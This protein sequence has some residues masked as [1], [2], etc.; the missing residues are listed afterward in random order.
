[1]KIAVISDTHLGYTRFYED[2][3]KQAEKAFAVAQEIS[4][5]IIFAG[6]MFDSKIPSLDTMERA[7]RILRE[8]KVPIYGISGNHERR[9]HS[10]DVLKVF[11][12]ARMFKKIGRTG[13]IIEK[14]GERIFVVGM[15]SLP[16][17]LAEKGLEKLMKELVL[18]KGT[19]SILVLHQT[20]GIGGTLLP[21]KL[22]GLPFE[23]IVNGHMHEHSIRGKILQP[24]STVITQLKKEETKPK[25]FCIYNTKTKE[26]EFREI[27]S[28]K[29]IME[30][31]EFENAGI[32]ELK[33]RTQKRI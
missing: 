23:L 18:P 14:N 1:M 10:T 8:I 31:L 11:E 30:T 6:D 17:D 27:D 2:S 28:R 9:M 22:D 3:F 32:Q 24:G 15:N 33:E 25:G 29:F 12:S 21:E 20:L 16:E 26:I 4:D 7:V 5:V 19:H 13:S